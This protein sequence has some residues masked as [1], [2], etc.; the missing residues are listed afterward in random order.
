MYKNYGCIV[1]GKGKEMETKRLS[2]VLCALLLFSCLVVSD[3]Y[4]AWLR[5]K[6]K[7]TT[8]S[9][10][11]KKKKKRRFFRRKKKELTTEQK[12]KKA[13]EAK[14]V[15][16]LK[17][18]IDRIKDD[19]KYV[20]YEHKNTTGKAADI[21]QKAV[22]GGRFRGG[23]IREMKA[24]SEKN[25]EKKEEELTARIKKAI[26]D[27]GKAFAATGIGRGRK[28]RSLFRKKGVVAMPG[29]EREPMLKL[30]RT[31]GSTFKMMIIPFLESLGKLPALPAAVYKEVGVEKEKQVDLKERIK[32]ERAAVE[33]Y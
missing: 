33:E 13:E 26:S 14:Q 18:E 28:K 29:K 25:A 2:R 15:A 6:K 30:V 24:L 19:I 31:F 9:P 1:S 12:R 20:T 17:L 3:S 8:P 23:V 11:K 4:G 32:S 7:T 21:I 16:K 10:T 22:A 5:K 27:A